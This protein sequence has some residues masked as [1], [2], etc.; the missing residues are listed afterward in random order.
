M[1]L[2][3]LYL[4]PWASKGESE[5]RIKIVNPKSM[6]WGSFV[7]LGV[8]WVWVDGVCLQ[9]APEDRKVSEALLKLHWG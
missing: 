6:F 8:G 4:L 9:T 2:G 3:D 7:G 1:N 5:S